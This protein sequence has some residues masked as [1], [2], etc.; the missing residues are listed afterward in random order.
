M[1]SNAYEK[2]TNSADSRIFCMHSYDDSKD[3]QNL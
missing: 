2:P 1:E 3:S